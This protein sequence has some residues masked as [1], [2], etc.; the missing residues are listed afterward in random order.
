MAKKT[1]SAEDYMYHLYLHMN[2]VDHFVVFSGLSNKQMLQSIDLPSNLLLLK[3]NY[4]D[5]SFNIHTQFDFVEAPEISSFMKKVEDAT[6]D[7]CWVD[8]K[9]ERYVN[10]L[11]PLEQ[12][13][14]LYFSHKHEPLSNPFFVKLQNRF[15]YYYSFDDK[16]S[17]VYFRFLADSESIVATLF[18]KMIREKEVSGSFWRRKAKA[19]VPVIDPFALK[20]LRSI[21][22]EG[23]LFSLYKYDKPSSTYG[24]EVRMLS[25]FSFPDEV[26]DDLDSILK[27]SYD[28]H[29]QIS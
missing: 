24:L 8:F 4:E 12:A 17:K 9:E 26:W 15:M 25:D 13:D 21:A 5:G 22:K 27:Q 20:A 14:L 7:L 18:N 3:H 2:E 11:T 10:Q 19:N 29:I 28:E 6:G 23:A 16:I 1:K